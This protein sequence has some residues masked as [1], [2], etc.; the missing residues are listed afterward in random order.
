[1]DSLDKQENLAGG[2][3][4]VAIGGKPKTMFQLLDPTFI[5]GVGDVLTMGAIKYSP[6]NWKLVDREQYERAMYHH[7]NEYFKGVKNDDESG[8][9]HLYH[10]ACNAM[11][12]D[13]FDR[14]TKTSINGETD[15]IK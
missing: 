12:L 2:M 8:L 7:M 5:E 9:S 4:E 10:V 13:W 3:K 15:G 6:N 1:M 14:D 11:F